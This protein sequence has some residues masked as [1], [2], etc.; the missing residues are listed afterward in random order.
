MD[1]FL[2]AGLLSIVVV[3]LDEIIGLVFH[4][5][6]SHSVTIFKTSAIHASAYRHIYM[7]VLMKDMYIC[8]CINEVSDFKS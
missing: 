8:V 6:I 2:L 4:I 1:Y 5:S 7:C 3:F